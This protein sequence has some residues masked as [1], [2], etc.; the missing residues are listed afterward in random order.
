MILSRLPGLPVGPGGGQ[1]S[2]LTAGRQG[3]P[4][5]SKKERR[6]PL[7]VEFHGPLMEGLSAIVLAITECATHVV[8]AFAAFMVTMF[9]AMGQVVEA[10]K[11]WII[12]RLRNR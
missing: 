5:L 4:T 2:D 6:A 9:D 12:Q 7:W 3:G 11:E 1:G 8:E 10:S